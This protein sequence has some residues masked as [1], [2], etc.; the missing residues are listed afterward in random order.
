M[1]DSDNND[2]NSTDAEYVEQPTDQKD[3]AEFLDEYED[4]NA[5]DLERRF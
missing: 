4:F 5:Q 1:V 2:V 3:T